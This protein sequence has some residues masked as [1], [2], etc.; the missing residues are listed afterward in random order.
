MQLEYP[1]RLLLLL[2]HS[3]Q[4]HWHI[5]DSPFKYSPP[6]WGVVLR[7]WSMPTARVCNLQ[8]QDVAEQLEIRAHLCVRAITASAYWGPCKFPLGGS[9]KPMLCICSSLFELTEQNTTDRA[10]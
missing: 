9:G 1:L 4:M 2:P 10:A 7:A 8:Y 6:G 3:F 5:W